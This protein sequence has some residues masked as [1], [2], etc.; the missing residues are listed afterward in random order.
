[1]YIQVPMSVF[2]KGEDHSG[3]VL[4]VGEASFDLVNQSFPLW[5]DSGYVLFRAWGQEDMFPRPVLHSTSFKLASVQVRNV[6]HRSYTVIRRFTLP[7]N[8]LPVIL[9]AEN[10]SFQSCPKSDNCVLGCN[11]WI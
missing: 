8:L 4:V 2:S 6:Y 10:F 3:R 11:K 1:M 9:N 7:L 5:I